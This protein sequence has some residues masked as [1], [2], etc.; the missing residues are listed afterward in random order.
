MTK[1]THTCD[2]CGTGFTL[3]YD[4]MQAEDSP[5]M[6]PFCGYYIISLDEDDE[7]MDI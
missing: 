2:D 3:E 4:E 6:C 1:L 7:S 5:S